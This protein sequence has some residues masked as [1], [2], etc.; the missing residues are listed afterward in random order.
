MDTRTD[1]EKAWHQRLIMW[2]SAAYP[3]QRVKGG[4]L[5]VP[6]CGIK[7]APTVYKTKRAAHAAIEAYEAVLRDKAAG[8]Y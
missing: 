5:W 2:G 1:D 4:W 8:R 7:G 3:I 6:M